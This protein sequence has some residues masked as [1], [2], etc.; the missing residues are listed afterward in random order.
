MFSVSH[1]CFTGNCLY[2]RDSG[3]N[4]M[5]IK[6]ELKIVCLVCLMYA[7][8]PASATTIQWRENKWKNAL[9]HPVAGLL[10]SEKLIPFHK[11]TFQYFFQLH[12]IFHIDKLLQ[13]FMLFKVAMFV[14]VRQQQQQKKVN[15]EGEK[16]LT[17]FCSSDNIA[18][19]IESE[20]KK[21]DWKRLHCDILENR[22]KID[23]VQKEI[24]RKCWVE[25]IEKIIDEYGKT[26]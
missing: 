19:A 11:I 3:N 14:V 5:R 22:F 25:N 16:S 15:I 13:I 24:E 17:N 6:I 8:L 20:W 2:H 10:K 1:V 4:E 21:C 23:R 12:S 7:K 26:L 18:S 9:L